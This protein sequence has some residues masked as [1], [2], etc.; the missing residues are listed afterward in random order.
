MHFRD[1]WKPRV[2]VELRQAEAGAWV[3][4]MQTFPPST[5]SAP[6]WPAWWLPQMDPDG[7]LA[8]GV[9]LRAWG[10]DV[11]HP[12]WPEKESG[13]LGSSLAGEGCVCPLG[14]GRRFDVEPG[15]CGLLVVCP[16][17]F[18][19]VGI[20]PPVGR[21]GCQ[22]QAKPRSRPSLLFWFRKQGCSGAHL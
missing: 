22:A 15:V 11:W 17:L 13:E 21:M 4:F 5:K 2:L 8:A 14:A 6:A 16:H 10:L 19:V 9:V 20:W 1:N 18:C 3:G 12:E 7:R